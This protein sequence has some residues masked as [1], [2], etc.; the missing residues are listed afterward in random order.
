M[1]EREHIQ[2]SSGL[3]LVPH[4]GPSRVRPEFTQ[5][6]KRKIFSEMVVAELEGGLL[7]Y[8]RR[9]A[10]IRFADDMGIPPFDANL[11]IAQAQYRARQLD[12]IEFDT[13]LDMPKATHP[14]VWPAGYRLAFALI[15]A[16][17]VN[18]LVIAWIVG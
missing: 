2:T 14:E 3:R 5:A 17:I 12:P 18:L 10:L 16:A 4:G 6:E 11:L 8:S 9:R 15:T 1:R 13:L 7:R